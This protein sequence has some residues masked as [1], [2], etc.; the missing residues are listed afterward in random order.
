ME[1]LA[2]P[3]IDKP[4]IAE[5]LGG[6][7]VEQ[8]VEALSPKLAQTLDLLSRGYSNIETGKLLNRSEEAIRSRRRKIIYKLHVSSI[9]EAVSRGFEAGILTFE[10]KSEE[11][12]GELT[13]AELHIL[14][15]A[16]RGLSV[17]QTANTRGTVR[18]T[19]KAQRRNLYA[20]L[21]AHDLP[22]AIRLAY[23]FGILKLPETVSD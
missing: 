17:Q 11:F 23:E 20:E 15:L 6:L 21:G 2:R 12:E 5:P 8:A 4:I 16:S 10:D 18:E 7:A 22:H 13:S 1:T 3:E 19:A 9:A 14:R